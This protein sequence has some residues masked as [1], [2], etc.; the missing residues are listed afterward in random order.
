MLLAAFARPALAQHA[1]AGQSAAAVEQADAWTPEATAALEASLRSAHAQGLDAS[2]LAHALDAAGPGDPGRLTA[3]ALAYAR[4]L[5]FGVVDPKRVHET[6]SLQ[7]NRGDLAG[8][9][10]AALAERRLGAWLASLPPHDETY[11]ALSQA[12]LGAR[13]ASRAHPGNAGLRARARTLALNLERL[14]W[15]DRSPPPTRIDVN[16]AAARLWFLVDGAVLDSRKVVAG[17]RGHETPLLQAS[18]RRIVVN[19]PWIVPQ[20]IAAKEIL[21]K[22]RRYLARHDMRIVDGRVIQEAGPDSSLGAVKFDLDDDQDIYLHDTPEQAAFERADRHLSHGCVRVE[23]A[24]GFA[25]LVA[26][27]FGAA[28][29]FDDRLASGETASVSLD[30][31]VPVRLLYLTA[32][33]DDG[34]VRFAKDA[35]GWDADL[36]QALG[37]GDG[38]LAI[39]VKLGA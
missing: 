11:R 32:Y 39:P 7:T 18:F 12:Y 31:D 15:L 6:F 22:G 25:H 34:E 33:V 27:Q 23:D 5:A 14:R 16:V 29:Q 36:A 8:E 3:V 17:A 21:P 28:D 2:V 38:A 30:A 24:V 26:E 9:L 35:Y 20:K 13:V 4:A 10:H 37:L 19:P 1:Q